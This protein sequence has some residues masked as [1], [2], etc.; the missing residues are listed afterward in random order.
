MSDSR[1][2]TYPYGFVLGGGGARGFAH[3]G[4]IKALREKGITPDIIS[5]VSAGAVAGAFIAGGKSA[6][7]THQM[8]KTLS[9]MDLTNFQM[10]KTGLFNLDKLGALLQSNL[11]KIDLKD[12]KIPF[13]VAATDILN[14]RVTYFREG[15]LSAIV[16]ASA[17]IPVLF[18]PVKIND[19]YYADGGVFSN[20]PITPLRD[21]CEQIVVINISPM[22]RISEL[23]NIASIAARTFQLSVNAQNKMIEEQCDIY[24][25]PPQLS[26]FPIFDTQRADELFQIGYEYTMK[27][28]LSPGK[29]TR[30]SWWEKFTSWLDN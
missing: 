8:L 24:I 30:K 6:E 12:L 23:G 16:Q 20:I 27:L 1:K 3:L 14:A 2:K 17:S 25:E 4:A 19:L 26:S 22:D 7:E 28:D 18:S 29:T 13:I 10:P 5:G 15:D 9:M 11:G 21:C